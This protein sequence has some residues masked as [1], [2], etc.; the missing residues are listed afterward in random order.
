MNIVLDKADVYDTNPQSRH[1]SDGLSWQTLRNLLENSK[2]GDKW[3]DNRNFFRSSVQ[4]VTHVPIGRL[5][6]DLGTPVKSLEG[7]V[8]LAEARAD[9]RIVT[10]KDACRLSSFISAR[11]NVAVVSI[12][13]DKDTSAVRVTA[14]PADVQHMKFGPWRLEWP[15]AEIEQTEPKIG[16]RQRLTNGDEYVVQCLVERPAK[17]R[18]ILYIAIASSQEGVNPDLRASQTIGAAR[19]LGFMKLLADHILQWR[20]YWSRSFLSIPDSRLENLFYLQMYYLGSASNPNKHWPMSLQAPWTNDAYPPPW[21]G[22]P[23]FDLDVQIDYMPT[24]ASNRLDYLDSLTEWLWKSLPSFCRQGKMFGWDGPWLG[25]A[26]APDT[27]ISLMGDDAQTYWAGNGGWIAYLFWLRYLYSMDENFLRERAYPVMRE[28]MK[29]Y[30]GIIER[31]EDGLFHVPWSCS[32]EFLISPPWGPDGTADLGLIRFLSEALLESVRVLK[33]D[34]PDAEKWEDVLAHL[35]PLPRGDDGLHVWKGQPYDRLHRHLTHLMPI[36]PLYQIT[37]DGGLEQRRIIERSLATI[38][39]YQTMEGV[40]SATKLTDWMSMSAAMQATLYALAGNGN[41][42]LGVLDHYANNFFTPQ[43]FGTLWP[44]KRGK[45]KDAYQLLD[46]GLG[47]ATA[48]M[49]ML[50]QSWGMKIRVFPAM[51]DKWRNASF[52]RLRAQGA[53]L[54]SSRLRDGMVKYIHVESTRGGTCRIVNPFAEPVRVYTQEGSEERTFNGPVIEFPT[55]RRH[56]YL[57]LP[58]SVTADQAD[59]KLYLP[60][61]LAEEEN[62]YGAR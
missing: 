42:S 40:E 11:R 10:E 56:A 7:R 60:A 26:T 22:R 17:N 47:I 52:C 20:E 44:Y 51:P 53:F 23:H 34:D 37:V 25:A 14:K 18:M 5:V 38:K 1:I 13:C 19:R 55:R 8:R 30:L 6:L 9:T 39:K 58:A 29:T 36:W 33:I 24:Y 57:L 27:T 41:G 31:K 50:L 43:G 45:A 46:C 35:A 3:E 54:V 2:W 59:L 4:F 16:W 21:E 61:R 12:G 62:R 28:F 49:D 15:Q 48:V 32:P